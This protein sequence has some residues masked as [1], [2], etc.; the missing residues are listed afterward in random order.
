MVLTSVAATTMSRA[1]DFYTFCPFS[2]FY[3]SHE[4]LN[5]AINFTGVSPNNHWI[6]TKL[7]C[8]KWEWHGMC[9]WQRFNS[10]FLSQFR[11][12]SIYS[13]AKFPIL[14]NSK[15]A[16]I[17]WLQICRGVKIHIPTKYCVRIALGT[18]QYTHTLEWCTRCHA[19]EYR[20]RLI[21]TAFTWM[22]AEHLYSIVCGKYGGTKIFDNTEPN[23]G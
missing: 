14:V 21:S 13:K 5:R 18:K 6:C 9:S 8:W 20:F 4:I 7:N 19:T 12:H 11:Y 3:N 23:D 16:L 22:K 1:V 10:D 2:L 17:Q 15:R